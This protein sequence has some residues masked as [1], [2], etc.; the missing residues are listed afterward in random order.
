MAVAPRIDPKDLFTP[1]EWA[2]ISNRSSWRGLALIA[3][4]WTVIL[5]A[6]AMAVIW[7]LTLPLAI[8]IIGGR[9]LGLAVLMHDATHGALHSHQKFNDWAGEWL[10]TGGLDRYRPYHLTHHKYVQQAEDPDLVLSAPFP[11]TAASLR[12]KLLRDLT[13]QTWFKQRF[14]LLRGQLAARKA[15][16]PLAPILKAE[17]IRKRRLLIGAAVT[18]AVTAPFGLWWVWFVLWLLP[19]AT[20]TQMITRLRNIAEH[21]GVA[22]DERDPFRCARTTYAG[23]LERAMVAPYWVNYHC[24]HHI[25][26]HLPCYNLPRAHKLLLAKGLG[27]QMEIRGS[28]LEVL[29]MAA[30]KGA[31]SG[32]APA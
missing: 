21:A 20:W 29:R 16:E 25:F 26:M 30:S 15:G 6:G 22:K 4:A 7:P 8:M 18:I 13:G 12:R 31:P 5:A 27:P 28:Y 3:H 32:L 2:S 10:T 19:Q 11:I 24:E 17:L 9:Q 14:G 1:Q 23:P